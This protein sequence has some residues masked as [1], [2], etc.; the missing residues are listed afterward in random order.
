[1]KLILLGPPGGGKGTQAV[2]LREK[3]SIP[4]ISTGDILRQNVSDETPL[5]KAAK[6]FMDK[7][8]LVADDLIN[9][10]MKER[11][12]RE[13]CKKGFL[14]DGYPRTLVQA[15]KLENIIGGT[16]DA[17]VLLEVD[18]NA[19]KQRAVGRRVC[20]KCGASFHVENN[21]PKKEGVC[22]VCGDALIQRKDDNAETVEGRLDV[23]EGII[24]GLL[25]H[26]E[27]QGIVKH[28]DGNVSPEEVRDEIF[29]RLEGLE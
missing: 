7:G 6:E 20:P 24:E 15:K 16:V 4:H 19:I 9:E 13:D 3:Y 26:Y 2:Y 14:L 23:Y 28:V 10:M 11:L 17:V 12:G 27:A 8:Q 29:R 1:M 5:G 18:R 25:A 22:D 21:P